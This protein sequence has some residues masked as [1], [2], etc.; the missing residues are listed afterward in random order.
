MIILV[1]MYSHSFLNFTIFILI[2]IGSFLKSLFSKSYLGLKKQIFKSL[3]GP[4]YIPIIS[5]IEMTTFKIFSIS[6]YSNTFSKFVSNVVA[7][8]V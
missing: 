3:V 6:L 2:C 7:L 4:I 8:A 5:K 1:I